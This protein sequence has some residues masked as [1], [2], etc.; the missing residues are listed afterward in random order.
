MT[1][2]QINHLSKSISNKV[3][4]NDVN[5][6]INQQGIYGFIGR[7]GSGKSILFKT[8][9]GLI[10]PTSGSIT[11]FEDQIEKG[12]FPKDLG[13]LLDTSGFLKNQSGFKNLKIL[14][15]ILNKITDDEI[16]KTLELVGLDPNDKQAIS[17]Y[18]LGMTQRL[19]IAQAI[20]EKPKLLI[21]DEPMN[22]LDEEGVEDVRNILMKLKKEGV[23]ILLSSHNKE[24]IE[25][26]C[27]T[28]Y[29]IEKGEL[30]LT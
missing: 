3:L 4:L 17:K 27:D 6:Q 21:V 2:I 28:V 16:K 24:D 20:M 18:S 23:T 1:I 29:K 8:I 5:L 7:N 25:I 26:L 14:A 19:G 12:I 13:I 11:V 9:C 10:I 30:T 15:S 22:A